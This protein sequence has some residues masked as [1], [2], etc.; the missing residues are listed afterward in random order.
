[1]STLSVCEEIRLVGSTSQTAHMKQVLFG[2]KLSLVL[3][4]S[5]AYKY[6]NGEKF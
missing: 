2:D 5:T 3:V 4:E 6:F 1:M